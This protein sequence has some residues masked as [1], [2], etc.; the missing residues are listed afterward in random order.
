MAGEPPKQLLLVEGADDEHVVRHLRGRQPDMPDFEIS[1]KKGFPNLR[2]AIRPE[3]KAPGRTALGILVDAN[4]DFNARWNA[5]G[6]QLRRAA[7][8]LPPP[9]TTQA[10]T[11][12]GGTPRVGVWLMPDNQSTGELE[13]LARDASGAAEN[14]RSHRRGRPECGGPTRERVCWLARA[15]V[16][17]ILR[18]PRRPGVRLPAHAAARRG[19]RRV[20]SVPRRPGVRLPARRLTLTR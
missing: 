8:N 12:V 15:V 20:G 17:L 7:I 16:R 2:D 10:G 9:P 1:D 14:G 6:Y 13:D 11:V 19:T 18:V 5:I 3:L 4:D